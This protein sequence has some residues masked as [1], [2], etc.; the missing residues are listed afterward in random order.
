M[1]AEADLQTAYLLAK[2][3]GSRRPRG[4]DLRTAVIVVYYALLHAVSERF[5][6]HLVGTRKGVRNEAA[7]EQAY[8]MPDH[9]RIRVACKK[10]L[11]MRHFPVELRGLAEFLMKAQYDRILASYSSNQK[12]IRS[13]VLE[14]IELARKSI[15][16]LKN[17]NIH[18]R[19]AF[20]AWLVLPERG[21]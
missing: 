8:R 18:D 1:K 19:R 11:T 20:I 4:A 7:W 15:N 14:H 12:L 17:S 9:R 16:D 21:N 2:P 13:D 3:I 10:A 5:A 6:N